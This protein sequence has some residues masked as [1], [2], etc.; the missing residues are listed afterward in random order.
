[1]PLDFVRLPAA[2]LIGMIFYAEP[3]SVWV[4]LGAALIFGA[5]YLNIL[6]SQRAEPAKL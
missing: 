6:S 2:A 3:L 1:M 4:F 5:N